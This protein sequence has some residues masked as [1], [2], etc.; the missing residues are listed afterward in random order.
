MDP[1]VHKETAYFRGY[2]DK[3]IYKYNAL[4]ELQPW[5]TLPP[6]P[7][8]DSSLAILPV[9]NGRKYILH[10]VGGYQEGKHIVGDLYCLDEHLATWKESSF[11]PMKVPRK[12]ATTVW[13]NENKCLIV[14]GGRGK[15][16][17]SR[18]VE[19]LNFAMK[20]SS[21]QWMQV[22]SLPREVFLAAGCICEG[23]LYISGGSEYI[24]MSSSIEVKSV[25]RAKLSTLY[26]SKKDAFQNIADLRHAR[27]ALTCFKDQVFAIC[28]T[29][30]GSAARE[31]LPTNDVYMYRPNDDLW[32]QVPISPSEN[33]S[34]CF[35]VSFTEIP[36][37]Q[38][39]VVGGYTS[40]HDEG[41]TK[42]VEIA[43]LET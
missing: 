9:D 39:M 40:G 12:E 32:K 31:E 41:C 38:L 11:P 10:T 43:E 4:R 42:S 22:T 27:S 26:Q 30:P 8:Q 3:V 7:V 21:N 6:C 37:P 28:G 36:K 14:A 13:D 16:G 35:A 25:V 5:S 29:K 2:R 23:Y 24:Q 19:V 18:T 1:V 17:P 33:R 15:E 20:T 34:Y